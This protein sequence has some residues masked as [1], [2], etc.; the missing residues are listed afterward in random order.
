M[1]QKM[2]KLNKLKE[3]CVERC[4]NKEKDARNDTKEDAK[5]EAKLVIR[6]K[7]WGKIGLKRRRTEQKMQK[8]HKTHQ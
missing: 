2:Q 7:N 4:K 6:C 1:C 3:K 8:S 5:I